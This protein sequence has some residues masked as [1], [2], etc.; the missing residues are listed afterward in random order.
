NFNGP[1]FIYQNRS[2]QGSADSSVGH[3]YLKLK[4]N[5]SSTNLGGIGAKI[6]LFYS[7]KEGRGEQYY[8][9]YLSRGYKSSVDPVIHFGL[10]EVASID[11]LQ[12]TWPDGKSQLLNDIQANQTLTLNYQDAKTHQV[13][14][15][16]PDP[17]FLEVT[18]RL[19]LAH[20]HQAREYTDFKSQ[21]LIPH[22]QSE[23]GLGL[24]VGDVDGDGLD[25]FYIGGSA[26]YPGTLYR[27]RANGSFLSSVIEEHPDYDDMGVLFFD[28]NGDGHLDLYVASGGSRYLEGAAEYQDRLYVNDGSGN[29][30]RAEGV[31]PPLVSSSSV[32]VAADF[33]RDGDLDLFV[34]GRLVPRQYSLPGKSYILENRE[35][36]FVDVTREVAPQLERI[37]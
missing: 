26:G 20:L 29:L 31:L 9:H 4:L 23:Y 24:A 7:G 28:V 12:I 21:R 25:D 8:E 34:G 33:D 13:V 2:A 35:G 22:K 16:V 15:T 30:S 18:D 6:Q 3:R 5:G 1:A 11:S 36:R 32:V 10:G 37:G 19:G 17:L 27:Q 14:E